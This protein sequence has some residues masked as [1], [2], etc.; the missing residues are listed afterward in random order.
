MNL[1][2]SLSDFSRRVAPGRSVGIRQLPLGDT[3]LALGSRAAHLGQL[4][5]LLSGP[6][7]GAA[8]GSFRGFHSGVHCSECE[9]GS[10]WGNQTFLG[11]FLP[12]NRLEEAGKGGD[13]A[14]GPR[15]GVCRGSRRFHADDTGFLRI[16]RVGIAKL[17]GLTKRLDRPASRAFE[18]RVR[19]ATSAW[20]GSGPNPPPRTPRRPKKSLVRGVRELALV[21]APVLPVH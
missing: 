8:L 17:S 15:A 3:A 6:A 9:W 4:L 13:A 11:S 7:S 5:G 20:R 19:P 2:G 18:H 1:R 21:L 10:F 16:V 12:A 14:T